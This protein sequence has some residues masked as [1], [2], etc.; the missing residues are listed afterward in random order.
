MVCCP[1]V[2]EQGNYNK[3]LRTNLRDVSVDFTSS[4]MGGGLSDRV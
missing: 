4:E 3:T 2:E 1:D